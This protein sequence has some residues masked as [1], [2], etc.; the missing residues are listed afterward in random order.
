MSLNCIII[1]S[2]KVLALQNILCTDHE[3]VRDENVM[4]RMRKIDTTTLES[5]RTVHSLAACYSK[6]LMF[7]VCVVVGGSLSLLLEEYSVSAPYQRNLH[8]RGDYLEVCGR[9]INR[10]EVTASVL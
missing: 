9:R 7:L 8:P 5:S 3:M 10:F 6:C 2:F 1:S 4:M